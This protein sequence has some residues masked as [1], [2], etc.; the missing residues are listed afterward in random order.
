MTVPPLASKE[1]PVMMNAPPTDRV[2]DGAVTSPPDSLKLRA[3]VTVCPLASKVPAE[4]VKLPPTAGHGPSGMGRPRGGSPWLRLCPP[5]VKACARPPLK[6]AM[7][8]VAVN[9]PPAQVQ[10]P[11]TLTVRLLASSPPARF[12]KL[13]V[14][15]SESSKVSVPAPLC[16]TWLKTLLRLVSVWAPLRLKFTSLPADRKNPLVQV[17]LPPTV[18]VWLLA[19]KVPRTLVL[20]KLP[21]TVTA[22]IRRSVPLPLWTRLERLAPSPAWRVCVPPLVKLTV[23]AAT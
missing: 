18:N 2:D 12:V 22:L 6:I 13:P 5:L 1:P 11:P 7:L 16:V 9:V 4:L 17:Q 3:T 14:A 19:S 20:L 8:P 15:V 23:A 21:V 10:S